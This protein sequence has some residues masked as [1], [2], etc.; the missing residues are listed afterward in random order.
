MIHARRALEIDPQMMAA[1]QNLAGLLA[2][3]GREAEA[4]AHRNQAYSGGRSL[5]V[6]SAARPERRVLVL[7]TTTSGNTPDR[8]LLSATRFTRLFWFIEY[9]TEAQMAELPPYD[10][11]FSAIADPDYAEPTVHN[12]ERFLATCERRVI[13]DPGRIAQTARHLAPTLLAGLSGVVTPQTVRVTAQEAADGFGQAALRAGLVPPFL[14]RPIGSHGGE[15]LVLAEDQDAQILRAP[16]GTGD[17]YLTAFHDYRSND[18]FYRK[19]RMFFVDRRPYPYHLAISANWMVHHA[20]SA[21]QGDAAR[22]AEEMRF[23]EHPEAAIGAA[24]LAAVTAIG[25]RIDLDFCGLDFSVLPDG[26][27]LVFEANATMLAHPEAED[28]P[29]APKNPYVERIVRAFGDMISRI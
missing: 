1:H 22:M 16:P 3:E 23:L 13:N 8:H 24:A 12:V 29:F 6:V 21:M 26:R 11:V 9:A 20:S 27:V 18:G 4:Q 28:G 5:L 2:Q 14:V 15:G 19:Y 7:T 10:V 17:H 25:E